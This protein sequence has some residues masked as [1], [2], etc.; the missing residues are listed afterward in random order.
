MSSKQRID[1]N[2]KCTFIKRREM[3]PRSM[4]TTYHAEKDVKYLGLHLNSRITWREPIFAKRKLLRNTL[5]KIYWSLL[6]KSKLFT[7]NKLIIYKTILKPIWTYGMQ[8]CHAASISNTKILKRFQS[9]AL[10]KIVEEPCLVPIMVIRRD[11]RT[12]RVKEEIRCYSSV[13][14]SPQCTLKITE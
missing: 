9:K 13:Q 12:P 4:Q 7:S 5:A 8:L 10:C 1:I 6:W 3:C 11:F 14:C 2:F